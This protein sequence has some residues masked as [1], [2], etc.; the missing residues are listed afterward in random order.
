MKVI[1]LTNH[2]HEHCWRMYRGPISM[3]IPDGH[4]VQQCCKCQTIRTVHV[5]HAVDR[6][7]KEGRR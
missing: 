4:T 1:S 3:V 2:D 7:E 5:D 6:Q